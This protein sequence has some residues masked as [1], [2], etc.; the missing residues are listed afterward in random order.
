M[1]H[2]IEIAYYYRMVKKYICNIK[3]IYKAINSL[4]SFLIFF[5]INFTVFQVHIIMNK[6]KRLLKRK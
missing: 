4:F 1:Y 5:K 6:N 3:L 2:S